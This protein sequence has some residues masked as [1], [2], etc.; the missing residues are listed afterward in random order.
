[1]QDAVTIV[2]L[3]EASSK[4][5]DGDLYLLYQA[6]MPGLSVLLISGA[7]YS[8]PS[9]EQRQADSLLCCLTMHQVKVCFRACMA[10]NPGPGGR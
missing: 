8:L 9:D 10:Y 6:C 1:M 4:G 7:S 3:P 5:E 2:L